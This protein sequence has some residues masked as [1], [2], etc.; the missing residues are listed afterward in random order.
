M[1]ITAAWGIGKGWDA[2]E[3]ARQA[4]QQALDRLVS[5]RPV[6]AVLFVSQELSIADAVSGL[7]G[8]L[9]NTPIWGAG[10][11]APLTTG[12]EAERSVVVGLLAGADAKVSIHWNG[13]Y[14]QESNV[15]A[16]LLDKAL[17]VES[18]NGV[19]LS[20]DGI[21]GDSGTVCGLLS[22]LAFPAAGFL[23]AGEYQQGKTFQ[24]G[25]SQWGGGG[26]SALMLGG[27]L[28]MGFGCAHG[29]KRSGI[30]AQVTR[31]R[32]V[33]VQTLNGAPAAEFYASSFDFPARDWAFA[34]LADIVR[35]YPLGVEKS[36][37]SEELLLRAPL[38]VQVDGSLR[39]NAPVKEGSIVHLMVGDMQASLLAA[40]SA[41]QQARQA[42]GKARPVMALV[43]ADLAYRT[44]FESKPG[45]MVDALN[46]ELKGIPLVGAYTLGQLARPLGALAELHNQQI[47]IV[48]IGEA[49]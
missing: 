30:Y 4:G 5:A 25:G 7:S 28:Q 32:N 41:V 8:L 44:L 46:N 39:M 11:V 19:I 18:I 47:M 23:A 1:P 13:S 2:R 17:H 36:P 12:G 10:T 6:L 27:K 37:A 26:L 45:T 34:P 40:A 31:S 33:W 42:L 21:N 29:W 16:R 9:G 24:V 35:L 38:Q 48:L 14:A 43:F 15:A 49:E 20:M 3:A 22:D